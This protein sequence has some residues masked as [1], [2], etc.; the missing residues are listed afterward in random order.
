M[1]LQ[2]T[3]HSSRPM[4]ADNGRSP[5]VTFSS[6]PDVRDLGELAA[7]ALTVEREAARRYRD[8]A[9]RMTAQ[10]NAPLAALF[11]HLANEEE[12]HE[13]RV[14]SW[15]RGHNVMAA[16]GLSYAWT[17]PELSSEADYAE[18]GGDLLIT[19]HSALV[20][21]VHNEER[22]FAFFVQIAA[23]TPSQDVRD[24]AE[25]MAKAELQHVTLLRL[26][27]RRAWRAANPATT[28]TAPTGLADAADYD[29]WQRSIL[30]ASA[31]VYR[32]VADGLDAHGQQTHAG[33]LRDLAAAMAGDQ[34]SRP[35]ATGTVE[36]LLRQ[37]LQQAAKDVD[38]FFETIDKATDEATLR[39]AQVDA[40]NALL[41]LNRIKGLL[42]ERPLPGH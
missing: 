15:A 13:E 32:Q 20:L 25:T 2:K 5:A 29:Q 3:P 39:Q 28:E 9:T 1:P 23:K 22:A 4:A 16:P 35:A 36:D 18:A 12:K 11:S 24:A 8:L 7:I 17:A 21:A 33:V 30:T 14:Q 34:T 6:A 26:E 38:I 41:R 31:A 10:G 40:E 37:A 42:K 27:R 19:P